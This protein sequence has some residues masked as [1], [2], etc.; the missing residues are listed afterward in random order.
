MTG[1]AFFW[2]L[3]EMVGR[4][5]GGCW[6]FGN[7]CSQIVRP[8][9]AP[10]TQHRVGFLFLS[11]IGN[12]IGGTTWERTCRRAWACACITHDTTRGGG[13]DAAGTPQNRKRLG[14]AEK[15]LIF[16]CI[17]SGGADGDKRVS[18][19]SSTMVS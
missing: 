14:H 8:L 7:F 18:G 15:S 11:P 1:L 2:Y 12:V 3:I 19:W 16:Y 5:G 6:L 17:R 4:G 13:V 9:T 10:P